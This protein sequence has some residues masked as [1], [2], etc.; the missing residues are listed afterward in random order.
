MLICIQILSLLV[1]L[2]EKSQSN[3]LSYPSPHPT[4]S[5]C[6]ASGLR[7]GL[8]VTSW[9]WQIEIQLLMQEWGLPAPWSYPKR[10]SLTLHSDGCSWAFIC[11]QGW[12]KKKDLHWK[13][14][15]EKSPIPCMIMEGKTIS[16][17]IKEWWTQIETKLKLSDDLH[18]FF[19]SR[20]PTEVEISQTWHLNNNA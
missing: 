17:L 19:R 7:V 2:W 1:A 11:W 13:W 14:I 5:R 6:P 8:T 20:F 12:M 3:P 10:W 18:F 15:Y 4:C 16:M 9:P